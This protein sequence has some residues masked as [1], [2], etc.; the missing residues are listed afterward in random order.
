MRASNAA[1]AAASGAASSQFGELPHTRYNVLYN[2]HSSSSSGDQGSPVHG[3]YSGHVSGHMSIRGGG[4]TASPS[5]QGGDAASPSHSASPP[6]AAPRHTLLGGSRTGDASGASRL[7]QMLVPLVP[8][9]RWGSTSKG[10]VGHQ[11]GGAWAEGSVMGDAE[12]ETAA[13]ERVLMWADP[14]LSA[15]A[16][17]AGL[18][19]LVCA[20]HFT[21]GA[22]AGAGE[23][24]L[25]LLLLLLPLRSHCC[26]CTVCPAR[27][28][29]QRSTTS[30]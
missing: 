20:R 5:K 13:V 12:A 17:A 6:A 4:G 30:T 29:L 1:A 8:L 10:A 15:R 19:A 18:Y 16:M 26:C 2:E 28:L 23:A 21:E 3:E 24:A 11:G 14:W 27:S 9:A 22:A 7:A 25:L